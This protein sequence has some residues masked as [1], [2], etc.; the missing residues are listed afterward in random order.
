MMQGAWQY[1][2]GRP[3]TDTMDQIAAERSTWPKEKQD[4]DLLCSL[5]MSEM[6]PSPELDDLWVTFGFCACHGEAEEQIL[7]AVYGE[8]IQDKKCT[9][10]ELY[11]AYDSSTLI[12]LFDSKK[13]GTRAKEIPHLEVVLKGSPRAFQSVWY[14]KQFVASRQEGKRRIPSIAVDYGFL[15][16]L[17][18]EAEHT[19]LEDLYHQLFTLPR[20]RFDPMQLH[21][22]CIQGK[23]YEYAEGLLKL[24]KKDQKVLKRLL[25][26]P[27]PL[28][29]L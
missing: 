27:Y 21:E 5:I 22:A 4:C 8:L 25:K 17:K 16:C 26:N 23:L 28:P 19:L 12:A 3:N 6:H 2:R 10:E 7:S 11:L 24:R 15:N 13:L 20:A 9:F 18:D 29:D 1:V 14:L